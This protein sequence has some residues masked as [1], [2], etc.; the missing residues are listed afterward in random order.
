MYEPAITF[1]NLAEALILFP[2]STFTLK[3]ITKAQN[4][5][6]DSYSFHSHLES[7]SAGY[8]HSLIT[9]IQI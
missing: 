3:K 6:L 2:A 4:Q 1:A 9:Y 5:N 7:E 8:Y